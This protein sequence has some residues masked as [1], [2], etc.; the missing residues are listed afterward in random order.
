MNTTVT[1][2]R[3]PTFR[4]DHLEYEGIQEEDE[5]DED[6]F[7]TY[8]KISAII[9]N[10]EEFSNK[11]LLRELTEFQVDSLQHSFEVK[12][13]G[14]RVGCEYIQKEDAILIAKRI[15]WSYGEG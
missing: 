12:D 1:F 11:A 15:L 8:E 6:D 4:V 3:I 5:F 10:P 13:S 2:P 9:D 14:I 7:E